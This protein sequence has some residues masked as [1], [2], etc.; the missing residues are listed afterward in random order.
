MNILKKFFKTFDFKKKKQTFKTN[1]QTLKNLNVVKDHFCFFKK[2]KF[3]SDI[4]RSKIPKKIYVMS[5]NADRKQCAAKN[6]DRQQR[7]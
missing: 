4:S 6:Y 5:V 7:S 3:R 2:K 1:F